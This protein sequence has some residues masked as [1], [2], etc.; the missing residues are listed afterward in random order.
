MPYLERLR[1]TRDEL[2]RE[3]TRLEQEIREL[4]AAIKLITEYEEVN[5]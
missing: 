4:E 2:K 5:T 1:K 3:L